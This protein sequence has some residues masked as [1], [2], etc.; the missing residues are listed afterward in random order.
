MPVAIFLH[1]IK[2]FEEQRED[3]K[4]LLLCYSCTLTIII[5]MDMDTFAGGYLRQ[6]QEFKFNGESCTQRLQVSPYQSDS[7]TENKEK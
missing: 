3:K 5:M 6:C 2:L 1:L 4:C 7:T